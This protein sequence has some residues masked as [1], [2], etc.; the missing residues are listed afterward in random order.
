M[1]L[2]LLES[3]DILKVLQPNEDIPMTQLS[4]KVIKAM[5]VGI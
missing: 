3:W 2:Y 5:F 4:S 1:I